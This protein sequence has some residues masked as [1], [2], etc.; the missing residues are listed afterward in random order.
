MKYKPSNTSEKQRGFTLIEL[1]V[2]VLIVGLMASLVQFNVSGKRPDDSLRY[3]SAR[4]AAIFEVA[5]E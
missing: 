4:F 3:E 1:M 5:A 2:V